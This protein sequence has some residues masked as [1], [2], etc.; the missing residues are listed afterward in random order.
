M[1]IGYN[2]YSLYLVTADSELMDS[3][4]LA[5]QLRNLADPEFQGACQCRV[6]RARNF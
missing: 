4:I 1:T 3:E 2:E 6:L 5:Q